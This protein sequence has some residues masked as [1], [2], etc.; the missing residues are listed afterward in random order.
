MSEGGGPAPC[1]SADKN[2]N[3]VIAICGFLPGLGNARTTDDSP[4]GA[5]PKGRAQV[6]KAAVLKGLMT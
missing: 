1:R 6:R 5:R 4:F 2:V 3:N